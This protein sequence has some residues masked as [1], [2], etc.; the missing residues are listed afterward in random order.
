MH[1]HV[2]DHAVWEYNLRP[3]ANSGGLEANLADL[4]L[5]PTKTAE[6]APPTAPTTVRDNARVNMASEAV[7]ECIF[8]IVFLLQRS[9]QKETLDKCQLDLLCLFARGSCEIRTF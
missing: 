7:L 6:A 8:L 5:S 3:S 4:F 2:Q 1:A 9:P